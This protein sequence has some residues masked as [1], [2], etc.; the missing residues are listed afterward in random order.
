MDTVNVEKKN[1]V[2]VE[3]KQHYC[4]ISPVEN[5]AWKKIAWLEISTNI[6]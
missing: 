6:G 2:E 3:I 1:T 4:K 5:I